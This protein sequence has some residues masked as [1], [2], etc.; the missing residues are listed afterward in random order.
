MV[1]FLYSFLLCDSLFISLLLPPLT[2]PPSH[3][4]RLLICLHRYWRSLSP[5]EGRVW[6][7][8][9][10]PPSSTWTPEGQVALRQLTSLTSQ[11]KLATLYLS[12]PGCI[13]ACA[14]RQLCTRPVRKGTP[15]YYQHGLIGWQGRKTTYTQYAL[16]TP[17]RVSPFSS[18]KMGCAWVKQAG[19]GAIE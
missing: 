15:W 6:G 10:I 2:P 17:T 8:V 4:K 18:S 7:W 9:F 12:S 11:Q 16:V 3:I 5:A 13:I 19:G 14:L 1:F